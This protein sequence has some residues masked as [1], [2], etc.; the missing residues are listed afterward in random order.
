MTQQISRC[1]SDKVELGTL[2]TAVRSVAL[3]ASFRPAGEDSLKNSRFLVNPKTRNYGGLGKVTDARRPIVV[4]LVSL[5]LATAGCA[6]DT[7]FHEI[8]L[9]PPERSFLELNPAHPD[10]AVIKQMSVNAPLFLI[11]VEKRDR[12]D[13]RRHQVGSCD[14]VSRCLNTENPLYEGKDELRTE[15]EGLLSQEPTYVSHIV[16]FQPEGDGDAS[17]VFYSAYQPTRSCSAGFVAPSSMDLYD[18]G[19]EALL[20]TK[21]SLERA[22]DKHRATHVILL[23]TGWNTQQW[24]SIYNYRS[25]S[26][27]LSEA[28]KRANYTEFRPVYVAFS[29]KSMPVTLRKVDVGKSSNDASENGYVWAGLVLHRVI[30]PVAAKRGLKVV[31]IGHSF[32]AK[33]LMS[34]AHGAPLHSVAPTPEVDL[35]VGLQGAFSVN[36]FGIETSFGATE[37]VKPLSVAKKI[38]LTSSQYDDAANQITWVPFVGGSATFQRT[39]RDRRYK[40]IFEYDVVSSGGT[41]SEPIQCDSGKVLFL[42]ASNIVNKAPFGTGGGAHSDVYDAEMA[43]LIVQLVR[44]CAR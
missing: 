43:T 15:I 36:R 30:H 22:L 37:F 31:A 2:L 40:G 25:W 26:H 7:R 3:E 17:C 20:A 24:E 33:L 35:L 4:A 34:A 39:H 16:E 9:P 44:A 29:W 10:A 18:A 13:V 28:A 19:W 12:H 6:S 32:G 1:E 5:S 11:G 23:S 41:I 27:E 42:D 8:L 38:V 14:T 21:P